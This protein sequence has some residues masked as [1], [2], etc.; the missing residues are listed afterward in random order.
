MKT[1]VN[2]SDIIGIRHK[3]H[4]NNSNFTRTGLKTHANSDYIIR[5]IFKTHV[6]NN[7]QHTKMP[8]HVKTHVYSDEPSG[9]KTS[10]KPTH[11]T[12]K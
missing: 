2:S 11:I 1:H 8:K 10:K 7:A 9:P 6:N 4:A 3:T 12:T 5:E